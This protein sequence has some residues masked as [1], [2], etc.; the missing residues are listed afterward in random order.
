MVS[1]IVCMLSSFPRLNCNVKFLRRLV[2]LI[3]G[4]VFIAAKV[5]QFKQLEQQLLIEQQQHR[6]LVEG[7]EVLQRKLVDCEQTVAHLEEEIKTKDHILAEVRTSVEERE[8]QLETL[9]A[10]FEA[11]QL[12]AV[13]ISKDLEAANHTIQMLQVEIGSR[14]TTAQNMH[15]DIEYKEQKLSEVITSFSQSQQ[16]V[17]DMECQLSAQNEEVQGLKRELETSHEELRQIR[18]EIETFRDAGITVSDYQ[19]LQLQN[20]IL[21]SSVTDIKREMANLVTSL[22]HSQT[23]CQQLRANLHLTSSSDTEQKA[24]ILS[25]EAQLMA[26]NTQSQEEI[27]QWKEKASFISDQLNSCMAELEQLKECQRITA[28]EKESLQ[29]S[30]SGKD[31]KLRTLSLQLEASE[32]SAH[33]IRM[34]L[35]AAASAQQ[36]AT[37]RLQRQV[38]ESEQHV[39]EM[40]ELLQGKDSLLSDMNTELENVKKQLEDMMKQEAEHQQTFVDR[41]A[42]LSNTIATLHQEL[43]KSAASVE[44]L[45]AKCSEQNTEVHVLM[46]KLDDRDTKIA[47]L[48]ENF[49]EEELQ[50]VALSEELEACKAQAASDRVSAEAEWQ[51]I[52]DSKDAEITALTDSARSQETQVKKY[53]AVIKKLKQQLQEEKV[54]RED[55]EKQSSSCLDESGTSATEQFPASDERSSLTAEPDKLADSV[56]SL[57]QSAENTVLATS[58]A[59]CPQPSNAVCIEAAAEHQIS[60]LKEKNEQLQCEIS[61]LESKCSECETAVMHLNGVVAGL[62]AENETLK[63]DAENVSIEM[64]KAS[65]ISCAQMQE[66]C[67]ELS[68]WK[69][70]ASDV[71]EMRKEVARLESE[72]S[73]AIAKVEATTSQMTKLRSELDAR[74]EDIERLNTQLSD[75]IAE[76]ESVKR[77]LVSCQEIQA[78][79]Q[80]EYTNINDDK[81]RLEHQLEVTSDTLQQLS[82]NNE[83]LRMSCETLKEELR[84][85]KTEAE[86]AKVIETANRIPAEYLEKEVT[87]DVPVEVEK[88]RQAGTDGSWKSMEEYSVLETENL[89]LTEQCNSLI[90]RLQEDQYKYEACV[91]SAKEKEGHFAEESERLLRKLKLAEENN[92]VLE[93][94]LKEVESDYAK[95]LDSFK[96]IQNELEAE[97]RRLEMELDRLT[98]MVLKSEGTIQQL[99]AELGA[100]REEFS[101]RE[102]ELEGSSEELQLEVARLAQKVET[103][104]E[105]LESWRSKNKEIEMQF[106]SLVSDKDSMERERNEYCE[107]RR[108]LA[109][110]NELLK[111]ECEQSRQE[112]EQLA[113]ELELTKDM[114]ER[115]YAALSGQYDMLST[116][117]NNYQELVESLHSK[118]THLEQ[119]LQ[120]TSVD[121]AA[122]M[123]I[124]RELEMERKTMENE[125]RARS[126]EL[127]SVRLRESELL[128]EIKRLQL[129]IEDYSKA[130]EELLEAQ[131]SMYML[132]TENDSLRRNVGELEQ[133]VQEL[134]IVEEEQSA[135]QERYLSVLQDN[136]AL[137][138]Q[139]KEMYE[140]LRSFNELA[141]NSGNRS[142]AEVAALRAEVETLRSEHENV[143]Q[144]DHE[145]EQLRAELLALKAI[146]QQQTSEL[147]AFRASA[148]RQSFGDGSE[149]HEPV[150]H[151]LSATASEH[152]HTAE[153]RMQLE[154]NDEDARVHVV[155]LHSSGPHKPTSDDRLNE[156]HHLQVEVTAQ[157]EQ[158]FSLMYFIF[159]CDSIIIL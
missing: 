144:R 29:A 99:V 94:Q 32:Q 16:L 24:A 131:S 49:R 85:L 21:Q 7:S 92:T 132:Q 31:D 44:S 3:V 64:R 65:D 66:V 39:K 115:K 86:A 62:K 88:L 121:D 91:K 59:S 147:Q 106:K 116:D 150:H 122:Q 119:Q 37:G 90:K 111:I 105:E 128:S 104:V 142:A 146:T 123:A 127:G 6:E 102:S 13:Q 159:D 135:L 154:L 101:L 57:Q 110:E 33:Q 58:E 129:Q 76:K 136:S 12:S 70:I 1:V 79:V 36:M 89:R 78:K 74:S 133:R 124:S 15:R 38:E 143:S 137:I 84:I 45:S 140:K 120:K 28:E 60:E 126:E 149:S 81:T 114:A 8:K 47:S 10:E 54:R 82:D 4:C 109:Q 67:T 100:E 72:K 130:D 26:I 77:E 153:H 42:L 9:R 96:Q 51:K 95:N 52:V 148:S 71:E 56:V 43:E 34:E 93:H 87:K 69:S 80:S 108:K 152:C 98:D 2:M 155:P 156:I 112:I 103:D 20:E 107:Q 48:S 97:K 17:S 23:E 25:L 158:I 41:E 68:H 14:D 145:C 63:A 55:L 53:V 134:G 30:L 113:S 73:D 19:Q 22:D 157:L 50:L 40:T 5:E 35:E 118:N 61:K 75:E 138:R 117:I 46:K 125:R 141:E 27:S 139:S 83:Q 151:K 18:A 11:K